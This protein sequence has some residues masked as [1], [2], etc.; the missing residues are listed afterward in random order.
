MGYLSII[1]GPMFAGKST[2]LLRRV[3]RYQLL[4]K[5]V[6]PINHSNDVRFGPA[7]EINTHDSQSLTGCIFTSNLCD[8][9]WDEEKCKRYNEADVIVIDELQFFPD[10]V[11]F[12]QKAID[13]DNK[14]VVAAGLQGDFNRIPFESVSLSIPFASEIIH[15]TAL[16]RRCNDG[17]EA[18]F[19]KRTTDSKEK[20]VIG[21]SE[22]YEAVCHEHF[23]DD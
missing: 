10:A 12:I 3:K 23:L 19:T 8:V 5:N 21:G 6:L 16:C 1:I 18:P 13:E 20:T 15:L 4:G 14:I 9:I 11:T 2:E 7:S 22:T 17:T